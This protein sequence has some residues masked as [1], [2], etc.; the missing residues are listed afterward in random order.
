MMDSGI[1][2]AE[3]IERKRGMVS[4]FL[5]GTTS[6][7]IANALDYI[8]LNQFTVLIQNEFTDLIQKLDEHG[9]EE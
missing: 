7:H 5:N 6:K 8:L 4:Q 2:I 3:A 1:K 9:S